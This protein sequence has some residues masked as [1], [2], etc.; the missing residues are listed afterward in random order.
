MVKFGI[1]GGIMKTVN[2]AM[3]GPVGAG[4]STVA[5]EAAKRLDIT[6]STFLRWV[7]ENDG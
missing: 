6:H 5:R 4:K 2:V 7:K 1:S 3:D